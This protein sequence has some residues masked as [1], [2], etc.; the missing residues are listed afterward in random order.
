MPPADRVSPP[1]APASVR[2]TPLCHTQSQT[3]RSSLPR[4]PPPPPPSR[5]LTGAHCAY[6][7]SF[8]RMMPAALCGAPPG[9][10]ESVSIS[11]LCSL[12][13]FPLRLCTLA[14]GMISATSLPACREP[15]RLGAASLDRHFDTLH[16]CSVAL[17]R[18]GSSRPAP[19]SC[20]LLQF[21]TRPVLGASTH[22]F[23][24]APQPRPSTDT[25][26]G[27]Y[28]YIHITAARK[29][30]TPPFRFFPPLPSTS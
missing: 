26:S 17:L 6:G 28:H 23:Y 4:L 11:F 13:A 1:P 24:S 8:N 14:S 29:P 27:F 19:I 12:A 30:T 15:T 7:A 21:P 20:L 16:S 3:E 9:G 5:H 22:T 2:L 18:P 10:L 25:P